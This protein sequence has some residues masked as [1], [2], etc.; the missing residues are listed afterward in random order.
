[1]NGIID[2]AKLA[3]LRT[4]TDNDLMIFVQ[5]E[6]ERGMALSAVVITKN[7]SLF[8]GAEKAYQTAASILPTIS[9][10]GQDD[11]GRLEAMLKE[12]RMRLDQVPA[13][14]KVQS[15]PASFAS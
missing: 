11:C 7:S 12:L 6:L 8:A 13:F 4:K 9:G 3:K 5:R 10:L 2:E 14:S 15:Y 1:L